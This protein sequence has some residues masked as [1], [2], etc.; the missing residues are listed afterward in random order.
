MACLIEV[1]F[2]GFIRSGHRGR[3]A[4]R[5]HQK[6]PAAQLGPQRRLAHEIA[7]P[8]TVRWALKSFSPYKSPGPD[9]IYPALLQRAG[10][11]VIGPLV[12]LARASLT[13]GHVPEA[14]RSTR[15]VYIPKAGKNGYTSPKD[16]RPISL[17]SFLLKAVERLVD[18]YIRDKVLSRRPLYKDQHA[19]RAGQSTETALSRVVNLMD[20]EGAFNHTSGEVTRAAMITHGVPTA[21]VE[22]TW[23]MLG[24]RNL[25]ANKGNTTLC[26]TVDSGC[27]QGGVLSP[28]LWCLVVDELLHQLSGQVYHPIGYADDILVIVRDQHLDALFGVIQQALGIVDTWCKKTGL[29]VNSNK[30]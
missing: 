19:S 6:P 13:L 29:S 1:H 30:T 10:E 24:N 22:W 25:T 23:H 17:T 18:R 20:I 15:V 3:G 26:G 4:P 14:W 11:T 7:T 16:F 12:R 8:A 28:L 9:G 5:E 2:L 27:P 21:V